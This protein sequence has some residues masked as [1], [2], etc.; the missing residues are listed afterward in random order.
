[1]SRR[2]ACHVRPDILRRD[3][4]VRSA[5][6]PTSTTAFVSGSCSNRGSASRNVMPGVGSPPMPMQVDCPSPALVSSSTI[7][8]CQSAASRDESHRPLREDVAGED[9]DLALIRGDDAGAVRP[10]HPEPALADQVHGVHGVLHRD[11]LRDG[12]DQRDS[13]VHRLHDG[14]AAEPRRHEDDGAVRARGLPRFAHGIE[15][16]HADLFRAALS[17]SDAGHDVR[18]CP[19][20]AESETAPRAP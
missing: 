1:M 5:D 3:L 18:A 16:W 10:D 20:S 19:A 2:P 15:H 4:L 7:L 14:I 11:A 9:A 12:H 13:G 6:S 8:V 17:G